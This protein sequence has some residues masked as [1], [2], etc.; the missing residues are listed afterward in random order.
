MSP[1]KKD[2]MLYI[3]IDLGTSRSVVSASNGNRKWVDSYIG[4]PKDFVAKKMLGKRVLFGS[5]A[6]EHRLALNLSR[7]LQNGVLKEGTERDEAA[8]QEL[9]GHL[10]ELADVGQDNEICVAVGVPAEA[11]KVNKTAIKNAISQHAKK[12]MVVSEPFSVAYG[13]GALDNAMIVDIGAGTVDFCIMH[14]TVPMEEDQRSILL[15]GDYVDEQLLKLLC[16]KHPE[17]NFSLNMVRRFKEKHGFVGEPKRRIKIEAPVDGKFTQFDITEEMRKACESP[18]PAIVETVIDLIASFDPEFQEN[19]RKNI[20]VAGG[21]SQLSGLD[22][23][24][25]EATKQF[26]PCTFTCIN[27]PLYAGAD[28]ALALASDMPEEF[29]E[30]L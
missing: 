28:G 1:S 23:Y 21:G 13:L 22:S 6:L 30:K 18:M 17:A 4:W 20:I 11:L 14:G 19:V 27:D 9:I 3:G 5:E 2:S 29:L 12:L 26:E 15:A 25:N 16:E 7:P 24:L 10:I 8:V